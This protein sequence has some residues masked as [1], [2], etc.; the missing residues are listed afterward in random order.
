MTI[1]SERLNIELVLC[2]S[3]HDRSSNGRIRN[4]YLTRR[5]LEGL[6]KYNETVVETTF[7]RNGKL[8]GLRFFLRKLILSV[9]Q[10][11]PLPM[12]IAAFSCIPRTLQDFYN[13]PS[14][15]V[16]DGVRLLEY[17]LEVR[18]VFPSALIIVDM[19]DLMSRRYETIAKT[20]VQPSLGNF[21]YA[22]P[23]IFG[24]L[25]RNSL[26]SRAISHYENYSMQYAEE[27]SLLAAD[28]VVLVSKIEGNILAARHPQLAHKITVIPPAVQIPKIIKPFRVSPKK[29][30]FCF[31]GSDV[32][33]QNASAIDELLRVWRSMNIPSELIIVGKQFR[34]YDLPSKVSLVGFIDDLL[35][36]YDGR[37]VLFCPTIV[38][39]GVKTKVLEAF[40]YAAPVI[41]SELA[42]EGIDFKDFFLTINNIGG[43]QA[44]LNPEILSPLLLENSEKGYEMVLNDFSPPSF[45]RKWQRLVNSMKKNCGELQK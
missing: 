21:R 30:R 27:L 4:L 34:D 17:Q 29:L 7:R 6:G 35:D 33:A 37:T 11:R 12:Q 23:K 28:R 5:A 1:S 45:E 26:I 13:D 42:Y 22:F 24:T 39:G 36:I 40:A 15:F 19:D 32:V 3:L 10:G 16:F 18:K 44:L 25:L 9:L 14:L 38:R 8:Q 31:V 2:R 20:G 41:G 43:V